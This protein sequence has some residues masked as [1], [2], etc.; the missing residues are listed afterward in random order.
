MR[1]DTIIVGGGLGGL[2]SGIALARKGERVAIITAGRSALHFLSGSL[3][4]YSGGY[5]AIATLVEQHPDHPYNIIG[6]EDL[7]R[8]AASTKEMFE[9]AGIPLV[10][11]PLKNHLRLSPTGA[12]RPAW[13]TMSEYVTFGSRAEIEGQRVLVVG[14]EGYLDFYPEFVAAGLRRCGAECRVVTVG[15]DELARLRESATEM[16]AANISR[17]LVGGTLEKLARKVREV[18]ADEELVLLPAV[19]GLESSGPFEQFRELLGRDVRVVATA[20]ASV[21]GVRMQRLLVEEFTRLGG[22]YILGD[23]VTD[24]LSDEGRIVALRTAK[25]RDEEFS[26]DNFVLSTGSFFSRGLGSSPEGVFESLF[27]LD[28]AAAESREEWTARHI[29]DPQLFQRFG[30]RVDDH[31]RPTIDGRTIQNLY[32]VGA[33]LAGA[34]PVKE[35]CGAGVVVA[36]ALRAAEEILGHRVTPE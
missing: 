34:D 36:T 15:L 30:V 24:Y 2:V 3:E 16:R 25:H 9:S 17:V 21:P 19:F 5:E 28:V 20:S 4:L 12:L 35:G 31:L 22:D 14:I 7:A 6:S 33:V 11:D 13:L 32:V 18:A 1:Y 23:R 27:G 29:L 8:Y 26:A 10:G